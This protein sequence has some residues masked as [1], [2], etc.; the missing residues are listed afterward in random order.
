M[1]GDKKILVIDDEEALRENLKYVLHA[2]GYEVQLAKDGIQGLE[3]LETFTPDLIILDLNMPDMGGI[4][5]YHRI[6][7]RSVP[8]YPVMVLTARAKAIQTCS[9]FDGFMAKPFDI[10]EL[11]AEVERITTGKARPAAAAARKIGGGRKIFIVAN[12]E[13]FSIKAAAAFLMKGFTV[14]FVA[15]G[16]EAL[17]RLAG[18][19][20]DVACVEMRLAD[21]PGEKLIAQLKQAA[22]ASPVKFVLFEYGREPR[23]IA[24][25]DIQRQSGVDKFVIVNSEKDLIEAVESV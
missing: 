5:F 19:V 1:T 10:P 14:D 6:C 7:E 9:V 16:A 20:P 13:P 17:Q 18:G 15:T 4:E 23:E 3:R 2:K 11:L 8:K 24:M 22:Q 12:D 21:L 25:D